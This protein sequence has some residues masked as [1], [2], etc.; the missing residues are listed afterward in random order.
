MTVA[1]L[2][3]LGTIKKDSSCNKKTILTDQG[4]G[5]IFLKTESYIET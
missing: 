5:R 3:S 1:D 4:L 2:A